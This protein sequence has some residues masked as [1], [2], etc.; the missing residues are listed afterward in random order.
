MPDD[1]DPDGLGRLQ[2]ALAIGAGILWVGLV[3]AQIIH[4]VT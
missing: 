3:I 1:D 2:A 4:V